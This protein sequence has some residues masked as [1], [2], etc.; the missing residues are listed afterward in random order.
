MIN[1]NSV[2][3]LYVQ[4]ANELR[5]S[6]M[7]KQ[8]DEDICM[9]THNQMAKHFG[10]SLRTIRAA[11]KQLEKEGLVVTQQGKGTFAQ[12]RCNPIVDN[13][14]NLTGIT[15]LISTMEN[16]HTE[17]TVPLFMLQDTP[18]QLDEDVRKSMG[19]K[20]LFIRRIVGLNGVPAANV[21]MFLP[22]KYFSMFSREE[23]IT[24]TVYYIYQ[25]KIGIK[26]GKGCQIIRA[27][28]ASETIANNLQIPLNA[29]ILQ[30]ER[31]AYDSN[32]NMIE[33]MV[34]S[35]VASIYYFKV[36]MELEKP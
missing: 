30:I 9:D 19:N 7:S 4:V 26:L 34:L 13:L 3:P 16:M 18:Y 22:G 17:V 35:Y 28:G 27:T 29:P 15:K 31:K 10:V 11:I 24:N 32:G 23:L 12:A 6:I 20:C 33:Y 36:E 21:D 8:H 25:N 1:K 5:D 14:T 2:I